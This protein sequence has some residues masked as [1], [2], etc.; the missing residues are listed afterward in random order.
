MLV[1]HFPHYYNWRCRRMVL[2]LAGVISI[3]KSGKGRLGWAYLIVG[4]QHQ[5]TDGIEVE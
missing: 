1:H 2:E 5:T 4:F 3:G